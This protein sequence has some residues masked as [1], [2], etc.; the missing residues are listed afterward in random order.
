MYDSAHSR[1]PEVSLRCWLSG[2]VHRFWNS[3][4]THWVGLTGWPVS[5]R[6]CYVS[7]SSVLGLQVRAN[8]NAFFFFFQ[9]GSRAWTQ[10]RVLARQR[11]TDGVISP[12]SCCWFLSICFPL[13]TS[14]SCPE[15][16]FF[17]RIASPSY[18][19]S[20]CRRFWDSFFIL[21]HPEPS[22]KS[23]VLLLRKKERT[24][25]REWLACAG[26]VV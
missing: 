2:A 13:S 20:S 8:L 9:K 21:I 15:N 6:D 19:V 14:L 25:S 10:V 22:Y 16:V 7:T 26:M 5:S 11:F 18:M 1:R 17:H 3:L 12:V 4:G 24:A 23:V